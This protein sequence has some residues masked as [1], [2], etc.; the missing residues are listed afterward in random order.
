MTSRVPPAPRVDFIGAGPGDP[1]L[2]T[3]RAR[4]LIA[5][6]EVVVVDVDVPSAISGIGIGQV[7]TAV[8]DSTA[9]ARMLIEQAQHGRRVIRLVTGDVGAHDE[10]T[11][12]IDLV[13]AEG[14]TAAV[15]PGIP[16]A[17][18]AASYAGHLPHGSYSVSDSR[19]G[20]DIA[21][22]AATGKPLLLQ[23]SAAHLAEMTTAL[24]AAGL[25]ADTPAW[26]T[27]SVSL[28]TQRTVSGTLAT[29]AADGRDLAGSLIAGIGTRHI[30]PWWE[31]RALYGYRVLLPQTKCPDPDVLERLAEHGATW[32]LV[33][34]LSVEPPRTPAQ[35]HRAVKGL[36]DG[37]Y[38]WVVFTSVNAVR[39]IANQLAEFGLDSRALAGVR[40]ASAS[41]EVRT[42]LAGLGLDPDLS[43]TGGQQELAG[44]FADYDDLL[45]AAHRVLL[46][47]AE[48]ATEACVAGLRAKGWEV[49]DVTAYRT[50]RAA[51]PPAAI[52]EQ[53]K[54]GGFSAVLFTTA[55]TVRNLIGIAGKPHASTIVA[56]LGPRTAE[57]A[58]EHGLHVDVQPE[59]PDLCALVDALAAHA[60]LLR[61][62]QAQAGLPVR[63][64]AASR[65]LRR[66]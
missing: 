54:G 17:L 55:S 33:P 6:A 12:E 23:T 40:I 48:I 45:D 51:P 31:G 15:V 1:A 27:C 59:V 21:A 25:D 22:L 7:R 32:Q 50:V 52:R 42:A 41:A 9:I 4:E 60:V 56:C 43:T 30:G 3:I 35:M 36:V 62:Q 58:C 47:R 5:E 65:R 13:R 53:I 24:A 29:L 49:E 57:A 64:T 8:G 18:A 20:A 14:L 34:T 61:E 26:L 11:D 28:P 10:L 19:A 63:R 44:V 2:L 16:T 39:A 38:Q 37:R 46:P 66:R